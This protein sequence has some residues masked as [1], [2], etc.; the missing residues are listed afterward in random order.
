M[1]KKSKF[2]SIETRLILVL[3]VLSILP[4]VTV[5]WMFHDIVFETIRTERIK[6]VGHV[7]DAKHNQLVM[8]LTRDND[9]GK[10]FLSNLSVQ[11]NAAKLNQECAIRLIKSYLAAEGA[12]GATLYRKGSNSLTVGTSVVRNEENATFQAGQLAKLSGTGIG[13][14]SSYFVSVAE[15]SSGLRLE[16]N[17]P[18]S[19]FQRVFDRPPELGQSGETFLADGEGYFVTQSRYPS[20]QGHEMN[21]PIYAHPM[22]ACLS[23]NNAEVLDLDYRDVEIIHGFRM[24]PELGSA[25]IMA[26][27]DQAEAFAPLQALQKKILVSLS[28]FI[29]LVFCIAIY[30]ARKIA[31][32]VKQ[33]TLASRAIVN[34]DYSSHEEV[35]GTDEISELAASF[36]TM[37]Q[38]LQRDRDTMR[39]M[40]WLKTGQTELNVLKRDEQTADEMANKVLAYLMEYLK[41]GVGALYLFDEYR[42]ELYLTA[43]YAYTPRKDKGERFR[44]GEGLIGQAAREQKIICRTDVPP[45]Y[46]PINSALG[47]SIPKVI[48]FIP[49]IH[50]K[51]L[52]G[53]IEIGAFREFNSIELEFLERAREGIAIG[54]DVSLAH[55]KMSELLEE[56]QHQ[57]EELRMQ[58]EELQQ[59][60]EE[61]EE[62]AQML[63]QQREKIRI[64]NLQAEASNENLRQ[65]AEELSR[66]SNYKSEFM[67]NMSHELRTPLNSL[68]ILSNLLAQNK[69]GNL[70]DK[71]A[72]YASTIHSAGKDLLNLISDIL[73]LSKVEA[74]QM[75]LHFTPLPVN[76]LCDALQI[77]LT[78]IAKQKKL[79]LQMD[80]D[81][82]TPA[83]F[84]CD[85]LRVQQILKN[86]ISNALKFTAKGKVTV[87]AFTPSA[88]KNPLPVPAIAFAV[89]DTGI[90]IPPNKQQLIF[91]A[92]RQADGSI[93]RKYGGTGL[94]LSISLQ[95][96]RAMHGDIHL[97]SVEGDGSVFTL[98]LPLEGAVEQMGAPAANMG[99]AVSIATNILMPVQGD[100]AA[101]FSAPLPDDREQLMAGDK[102]ILVVEDDL[103]FVRILQDMI[104]KRGFPVLL[105]SNG[106]SGI[107]LADH[108]VPSAIVLDVMLPHI[109]GWRVMRSLKDNPRTRHI[110]VHFITCLEDRQKALSMGA[111]GFVTK[112]VSMEQL[113]EVLVTIEGSLAK[114]VKQLLIVEDNATEARSMTVLLEEA[115]VEIT[116]AANGEEAITLLLSTSF[117]CMVLDL[118]LSDM[119]GFE[120]LERM[121]A[122]EGMRRIPVIIH[123]G[124]ELSHEDELKLRRY[125]ESI[126][127]KGVR[128]P[129]RLLNEVTLFL[130]MV[131][132]NLH[133]DKQRMIRTAIDKEAMLEGRKVLLV[134]DDMR[135]IFSISSLLAEKNMQ[136][137]EAENGV[138]ALAKLNEHPDVAIVLMDIMMP[139]MDGYTAMR[140]IRNDPRFAELPIIAM[141]A[142]ALKGDHEKC[143]EA[144]AS[145][146]IAKPVDI[147]KLFSLIRVWTFQ[148][149]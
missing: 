25:C 135:N 84:Q 128:S 145:D 107:A 122:M 18:S 7:A 26:H 4:A 1:T 5:G 12:E 50:A 95:L 113:N 64:S 67:A 31:K 43:T 30:L 60:N 47:E 131:E 149:A 108:Y 139:E 3:L 82:D 2:N 81:A 29:L 21:M 40:D 142:K 69:D 45:D 94:G 104:R 35:E 44:L 32:P 97:S 33:L 103:D 58:Q 77:L 38:S 41:A 37:A 123:S 89:S 57:A 85:E 49:L 74:G 42:Q 70:T 132:S 141:T 98:Y 9:R 63:E 76:D 106:E 105:A 83:V 137:I 96:A 8:V 22:K 130:H 88:Q 34:G 62:R 86:L 117:D 129:E 36:K 121:A 11:C 125:A 24:V 46:L 59:S 127:I 147:E 6:T 116:V 126:I 78:P 14:N 90:G 119:S 66:V 102:S 100:D 65:K 27:I 72:E 20:M 114:S 71:Q 92:F 68:M 48:S 111:I 134:D 99:V 136:V 146:Y 101:Y 112:P 91:Q 87:R 39:A 143:I 110:P 23:G 15:P 16:I 79:V 140:A 61:L 19:N 109:D 17:Y 148:R 53:V 73:D 115:G 52:V 75:Q 10:L 80:I 133:P 56:T 28:F 93:S 124:R 51:R 55:H 144:G 118:T 120:L 13:N 138:E 54:L